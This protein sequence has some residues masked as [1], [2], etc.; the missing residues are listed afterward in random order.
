MKEIRDQVHMWKF[1]VIKRLNYAVA[2]SFEVCTIDFGG[3]NKDMG[4]VIVDMWS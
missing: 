4:K 1:E 2:W 3:W